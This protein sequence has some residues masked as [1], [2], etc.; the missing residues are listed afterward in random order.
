M[1]VVLVVV[2]EAP[3]VV[4]VGWSVVVVLVVLVVLVEVVAGA[5]VWDVVPGV[6]PDPHAAATRAMVAN[7]LAARGLMMCLRAV[8]A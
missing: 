6:A 1:L 3:V 4:V 8:S 7:R 2:G 5:V